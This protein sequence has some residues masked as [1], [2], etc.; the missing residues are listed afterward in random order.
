MSFDPKNTDVDEHIDLTNTLGDMVD[1]KEE[2]K[3]EKFIETMPTMIQTHLI[4]CKDWAAVKDKAKSLEHIIQKC[5]PP[6]PAMPL[7]TTGATV[8]GLY[9]HITH[10]VD[11]DEEEIP[12]P[13]KGQNQ[14]KPEVEVNLK[15]NL[16]VT[17]KTHQKTK[18]QM[19]RTLMIT[20]ITIIIMIIILPKVKTEAADLL[21]VKAVINNSEAS[22]REAEAK[23]ISTINA[24]FRTIEFQEARIRAAV[25][26]LA[27]NVNLISREI[28]QIPIEDEAVAGVLNK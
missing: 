18:R 3:M 15:E 16:K 19:K 14:S 24:N 10:L 13:F 9:S 4:I 20:L 27:A 21:M 11:K 25:I 1:Q 23:D 7:V 5:D 28:N 12:P 8:P 6:T 2:A 22:H 17:D 26:N